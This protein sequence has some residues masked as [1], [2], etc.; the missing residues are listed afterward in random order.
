MKRG[1]FLG[2]IAAA[3][4]PCFAQSEDEFQVLQKP[5][6]TITITGWSGTAAALAVPAGIYGQTVNEIGSNA[7]SGNTALTS[8]IIPNTVT[9]IGNSAF[10]NC[11][12]LA[13][14]RFGSG[15]LS[16]GD[17]AFSQTALRSL[18]LPAGLRSIGNEAFMGNQLSAVVI[19]P[20]VN[21]IGVDAFAKNSALAEIL[22]GP[23]LENVFFNA[24]GSGENQLRLI[25]V[26]KSG[27]NLG[28][29]GLDQSFV[30]VYGTGGE[31]VYV[32]RGNVWLKESVDPMTYTLPLLAWQS[33]AAGMI[34]GSEA[35]AGPNAA[36]APPS[37][38]AAAPPRE[39]AAAAPGASSSVPPDA[40][41]ALGKV[42]TIY[43]PGNAASFTGLSP[44]LIEANKK[45]L[46]D[47]AAAL[48]AYP[49]LSARIV[50][51]ANPINPSR[52]EE[53]AVLVPL[54]AKRAAAV[55]GLLEF[56]GI[57]RGRMTV[58]GAGSGK[59]LARLNQRGDWYRNR[60][61]EITI[62]W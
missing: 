58:S 56:N 8:V 6:G 13:S 57:S 42:Y 23:G 18:D 37:A 1:F 55:A 34:A 48:A 25:V 47:A 60:R 49:A 29:I 24:F 41:S 38:S 17:G 40:A 50:G 7:F 14:V 22:L 31:G 9:I 30:N 59:P 28:A 26:Q 3:A 20:A 2:L 45:A 12:K 33:S 4:L 35:A 44:A 54:S 52:R 16:I 62:V 11:A 36:A 53:R 10:S 39:S 51:Y 32:K 19:P 43:F 5:D 27:L 46:E 21:R 15:V 61:V